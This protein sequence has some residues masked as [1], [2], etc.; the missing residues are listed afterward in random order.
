MDKIDDTE[1]G[2][3]GSSSICDSSRSLLSV[4]DKKRVIIDSDNSLEGKLTMVKVRE[5]IRMLGTNFFQEMT[6]VK[7]GI[8]SKVYDQSLLV[9]EDMEHA[10]DHEDQA[11]VAGHDEVMEDDFI[12]NLAQEGD[13]DEVFVADFEMAATDVIQGDEDLAAAYTTYLEARRK[14]SEKYKAP[15]FWP[16]S[17]GKSKGFKGKFKGKPNWTSRKTQRILESNC[18]I[19]GRKG[20]W[21]SECPNRGRQQPARQPRQRP[22]LSLWEYRRFQPTM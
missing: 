8:K 20:H 18:R 4:E 3:G 10:G 14:L 7:K 11:H 19:F 15:G 5:S 22:S 1:A 17:K 21:K 12:E 2:N 9:T 6:G 13:E 16:I